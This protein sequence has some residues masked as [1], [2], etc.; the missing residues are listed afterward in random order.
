MNAA[1]GNADGGLILALMVGGLVVAVA[2]LLFGLL[3][4][5]RKAQRTL[6]RRMAA[7]KQRNV[8]GARQGSENVL[9]AKRA[10]FDSKFP[11][12]DKLLLRYV[13]RRKVLQARLQGTGKSISVAQYVLANI[14]LTLAFA[15][16]AVVI[17]GRAPLLGLLVGATLGM[18]LPHFLV[19]YLGRRRIS[20]FTALF[21]EAIDLIVRGLKSGLP[22]TESIATVGHEL[23]DPVGIEFRR[24]DQ[25]MKLG[26]PFEEALTAAVQRIATAEFKF[27]VIS[28]GVQRETGGNLAETLE[29]LSEILRRR[30]QMA[31]KV[32]AMSSEAKA[33]AMIIGSLPFIMVGILG[34][35]SPDYIMTLFHD[36]RGWVLI[37][38]GMTS[39]TMGILVMAKMVRFE[40]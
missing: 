36:P 26:Q 24:I 19:G 10:A 17:L 3:G 18:G 4:G 28:L 35:V 14:V 32:K 29:N 9:G 38:A 30:R 16:V 7:L 8:M 37:G 12:F 5:D 13:P 34:F 11:E 25:S 1:A 33:S 27:F 40:I 21:P 6:K 15:G 39:M 23:A 31:M 2:F 20:N 22:I